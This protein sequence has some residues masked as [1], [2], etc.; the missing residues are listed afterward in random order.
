MYCIS[1]CCTISNIL[2]T[3]GHE[4]SRSICHHVPFMLLMAGD[5][6][7]VRWL[8]FRGRYCGS[9]IQIYILRTYSDKEYNF[10]LVEHI[11]N[12]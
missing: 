2:L 10:R 6:S 3:R 9:S 12:K 8:P 1:H 5:R 7:L 11:R 4:S